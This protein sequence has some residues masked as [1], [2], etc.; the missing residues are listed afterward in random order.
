MRSITGKCKDVTLSKVK[1]VKSKKMCEELPYYNFPK[2]YFTMILARCKDL[3]K[4]DVFKLGTGK[5][6]L[7]FT[8]DLALKLAFAL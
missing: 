1:T 4:R 6:R 2:C 8:S 3:L 5:A 7:V